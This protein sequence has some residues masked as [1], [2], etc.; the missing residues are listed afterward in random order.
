MK[1]PGTLLFLA[2]LFFG[3]L[4][5][6]PYKLLGPDGK[7]YSS[8]KK[9]TVG[10]HKALKIYGRLNCPSALRWIKKGKYVEHRIFFASEADA[11]AAGY[12]PCAVCM[13]RDYEIWREQMVKKR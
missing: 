1:L 3:N 2:L 11:R 7:F 10:G 9:G 5:A 13:K 8:K 6:R 4:A 12:R